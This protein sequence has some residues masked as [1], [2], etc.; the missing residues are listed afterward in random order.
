MARKL[1]LPWTDQLVCLPDLGPWKATVKETVGEVGHRRS[2]LGRAALDALGGSQGVGGQLG[3]IVGS[4]GGAAAARLA[5]MELEQP[6][7]VVDGRQ[8]AAQPGLHPLPRRTEGRRHRVEGVLAGH[9]V[10]GMDLGGAPVGDLV[11]LA[12][13][14]G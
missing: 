8:L 6:S 11:G 7:P 10:I 5:G 9:V 4:I 2:L 12:V 13:P 14:L 3:R 1:T